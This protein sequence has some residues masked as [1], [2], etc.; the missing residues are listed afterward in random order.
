[1]PC[2]WPGPWHQ[3][4]DHAPYSKRL[5]SIKEIVHRP[6][7]RKRAGEECH[8]SKL[9]AGNQK[10]KANQEVLNGG[11]KLGLSQEG[12]LGSELQKGGKNTFWD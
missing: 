3:K 12:I 1:M 7:I 10:R 9:V 4:E 2:I 8:R 6:R 5:Q 11:R